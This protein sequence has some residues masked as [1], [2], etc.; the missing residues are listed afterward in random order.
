MFGRFLLGAGLGGLVGTGVLALVSVSLSGPFPQQRSAIPVGVAGAGQEAPKSPEA[1]ASEAA[2]QEPGVP[3]NAAQ[4]SD[5]VAPGTRSAA[6]AGTGSP[7]LTAEVPATEALAAE[8][9]AAGEVAAADSTPDTAEPAPDAGALAALPADEAP[10]AAP[11]PA[12]LS[13]SDPGIAD[14]LPDFAAAPE[15]MDAPVVVAEQPADPALAAALEAALSGGGAPVASVPDQPAGLADAASETLPASPKA[16]EAAPE[17]A[18]IPDTSGAAVTPPAALASLPEAATLPDGQPG[19]AVAGDGSTGDGSAGDGQTGDGQTGTARAASR[20]AD[21]AEDS[22]PALVLAPEPPPVTVE[23]ELMLAQMAADQLLEE[24][25]PGAATPVLPAG[26]EFVILDRLPAAEIAP[27]AAPLVPAQGE[28]PATPA[29]AAGQGSAPTE[30]VPAEPATDTVAAGPD[31][32]DPATAGVAGQEPAD[33]QELA[34]AGPAETVPETIPETVP[35]AVPVEVTPAEPVPA[36]EAAEPVTESQPAEGASPETD[37]AEEPPAAEAPTDQ[38]SGDAPAKIITLDENSTLPGSGSVSRETGEGSSRLPRIGDS[39]AEE[40]ALADET[41]QPRIAFARAF[42][43]PANKPRF[44]VILMDDGSAALDRAALADLPFPVSFAIDPQLANAAEIAAFYR[45][46]G[47]EVIM[48]TSGLPKGAAAS[49]V[50]VA[51][52]AMARALPEAVAAMDVPERGFQGD[53]PLAS[54]VVPEIAAQGR[55]LVTWNVGLNAADQVAKREDVPAAVIFRDL[56]AGGEAAPVIRRY[57]DRA[58]FK[59]AQEGGVTVFGRAG[60][61]E[62]VTA[63]LEWAVEGR[64]ASVELAPVS[65]MLEID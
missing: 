6:D 47:Q 18:G 29:D 35:E 24:V 58:A 48:L 13:L 41:G 43:N 17:I 10:A 61:A 14:T 30:P 9:V 1:L 15:L 3:D 23:E 21:P 54:L 34:E 31:G 38:P 7:D 2:A 12:E 62:T 57:L 59:A 51:F 16:P 25:A 37:L 44:A 8:V 50:A 19:A 33:T 26:D 60:N 55:G 42:E 40:V 39:P 63:L 64:A 65:A 20:P 32:A 53:R 36:Q 28:Q 5:V 4:P 45:A 52:D 11:E 56:D 49:D 22:A 27:G 46:A